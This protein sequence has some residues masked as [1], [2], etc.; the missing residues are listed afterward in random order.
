MQAM[1]DVVV[2]CKRCGNRWRPLVEQPKRCPRCN[3][4]YWDRPRL[5]KRWRDVPDFIERMA[6]VEVER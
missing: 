2:L 1:R 6:G 5:P 4:A 3:S